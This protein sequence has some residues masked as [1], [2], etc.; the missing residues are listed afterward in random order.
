MILSL[1]GITIFIIL[2][3]MN[4]NVFLYQRAI[5]GMAMFH[6]IPI[7]KFG[8]LYWKKHRVYYSLSK[9][10]W[11]VII[12]LFFVSW[13][14]AVICLAINFIV[15]IVYPEP[16]HSYKLIYAEAA[17]DTNQSI[18]KETK[19]ILH[20]LIDL[21]RRNI[22]F[23]NF[24]LYESLTGECIEARDKF[25]INSQIYQ[26]KMDEVWN[27]INDKQEFERYLKYSDELAERRRIEEYHKNNPRTYIRYER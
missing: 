1:V 3:Y 26:N 4:M 19:E 12:A 10:R 15:P 5:R 6:Q 13:I 22:T 25:G 27:K 21:Y 23:N 7:E 2:F 18:D 8:V 24:M 17:I 14:P 16:D 11:L 9:L 20:T